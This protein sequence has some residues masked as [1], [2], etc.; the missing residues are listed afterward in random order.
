MTQR[1]FGAAAVML[2]LLT[3]NAAPAQTRNDIAPESSP[4]YPWWGYYQ[5]LN[6]CMVWDGY[7]WLN[8]CWRSRTIVRPP[9]A[10]FHR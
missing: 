1:F 4:G 6:R 9:W 5:P 7:Q 2:A 10:R 8:M 3:S